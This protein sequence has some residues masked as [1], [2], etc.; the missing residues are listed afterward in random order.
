MGPGAGERDG[1]DENGQSPGP[2]Y[3]GPWAP[4]TLSLIPEDSL[5]FP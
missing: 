3:P 1:N 4:S 2:G 5:L